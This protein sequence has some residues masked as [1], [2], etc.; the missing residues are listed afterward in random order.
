MNTAQFVRPGS[1]KA[2]TRGEPTKPLFCSSGSQVVRSGFKGGDFVVNQ[3][4]SQF[5]NVSCRR[6]AQSV[7][8]GSNLQCFVLAGGG[9]GGIFKKVFFLKNLWVF[10]NFF[11]HFLK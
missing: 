7:L 11:S 5:W 8:D 4:H 6:T 2:P 3:R 9:G 10:K 1:T